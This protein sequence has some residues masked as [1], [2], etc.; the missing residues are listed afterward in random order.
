MSGL[1]NQAK[2][3]IQVPVYTVAELTALGVPTITD[4]FTPVAMCSDA[5]TNATLV[6]SDGTNWLRG[7]T[8]AIL[9]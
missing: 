6:F 8:G 1:F 5:A 4:G 7:D 9:S 2:G 3:G